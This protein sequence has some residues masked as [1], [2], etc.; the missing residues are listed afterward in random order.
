MRGD[1]ELQNGLFR[2][3]ILFSYTIKYTSQGIRCD[4]RISGR[5]VPRAYSPR[6]QAKSGV[7]KV[8]VLGQR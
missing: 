2:A 1:N 6:A 4:P 7:P 8:A 3:V 5:Q